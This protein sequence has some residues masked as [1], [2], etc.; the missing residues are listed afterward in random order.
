MK[1]KY[2]LI[3]LLFVGLCAPLVGCG[4]IRTE[5]LHTAYLRNTDDTEGPYRVMAVVI[6]AL[7]PITVSVVY[8]IDEW[9]TQKSVEMKKVS[10]DVYAGELPGQQPGTT[11][12]YYISVID[13]EES[14]TTD[15]TT[16]PPNTEGISYRF[17]I[18][19]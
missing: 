2:M 16:V 9:K 8:S 7:Q 1:K 14:L 15:P 4:K 3:L 13:S 17:Q 11:I 6:S 12:N 5:V 19:P 10:D 18:V